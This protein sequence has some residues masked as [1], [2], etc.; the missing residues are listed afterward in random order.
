MIRV[1]TMYDFAESKWCVIGE[2]VFNSKY[3]SWRKSR[4][5]LDRNFFHRSETSTNTSPIL[6]PSI[7]TTWSK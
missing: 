4:F 6:G 7:L 2:P 5:S 3:N 1:S